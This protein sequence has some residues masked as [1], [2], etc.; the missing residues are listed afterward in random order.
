[1]HP[2]SFK[3]KIVEG[4]M[5]NCHEGA[6]ANVLGAS[7]AKIHRRYIGLIT[8]EEF[9]HDMNTLGNININDSLLYIVAVHEM[10]LTLKN[11]AKSLGFEVY[12]EVGDKIEDAFTQ[13][14]FHKYIIV[15]ETQCFQRF[16]RMFSSF[17]NISLSNL[18]SK[19]FLCIFC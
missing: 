10:N 4:G 19:K 13:L 14:K 12:T 9:I 11:Y 1:M 15:H 8:E 16:L 18:S 2:L 17:D 3:C 7:L 6:M 5:S